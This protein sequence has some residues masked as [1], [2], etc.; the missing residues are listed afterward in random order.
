M[1]KLLIPLVAVVAIAAA[2][3]ASPIMADDAAQ[4]GCGNCPAANQ[5]ACPRTEC[6]V[7]T[8]GTAACPRWEVT[9][10]VAA[11]VALAAETP[12]PPVTACPR[13][14]DGTCPNEGE[15]CLE[16][17]GCTGREEGCGRGYRGPADGTTVAAGEPQAGCPM[18]DEDGT[19]TCPRTD[20]DAPCY[21]DGETRGCG[22]F[23]GEGTVTPVEGRRGCGMMR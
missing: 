18:L 21:G 10:P 5:T 22:R 9:P 19:T 16:G 4:R 23:A 13:I 11:G 1:K 14:T 6:P 8:D 12:V 3:L 7:V 15:G 2:L 20:E 17:E